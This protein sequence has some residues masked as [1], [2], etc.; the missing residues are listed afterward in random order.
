MIVTLPLKVLGIFMNFKIGGVVVMP[1]TGPLKTTNG[2]L[3][4][5]DKGYRS[6][7]DKKDEHAE[8]GYYSVLLKDFNV[9]AELTATERVGYHRYTFPK[10]ESAHLNFDLG[11]KQ[12]ESSD[13]IEAWAKWNGKE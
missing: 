6:K 13:V 9:K 8:P 2:T 1:T 4:N 10:S 5:P 3:E 12:G 11:H 7:F